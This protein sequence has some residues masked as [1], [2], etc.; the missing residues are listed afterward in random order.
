[1]PATIHARDG[2]C[3]GHVGS[4]IGACRAVP[5]N[6]VNAHASPSERDGSPDGKEPPVPSSDRDSDGKFKEGNRVGKQFGSG[7]V[8]ARG[9]PTYRKRAELVQTMLQAVTPERLTELIESLLRRAMDGDALC[10]KLILSYCLGKAPAAVNPDAV[11]LNEWLLVSSWPSSA[12][13]MVQAHDA[14]APGPAADCVR[15][16]A[17]LAGTAEQVADKIHKDYEMEPHTFVE[18]YRA[19]KEARRRRRPRA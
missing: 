18:E 2:H 13:V 16:K 5:L 7:Q 14:V 3:D 6:G 8:Q 15:I 17:S 19:E 9:N 10:A 11:N 1:M 12:A 4:R